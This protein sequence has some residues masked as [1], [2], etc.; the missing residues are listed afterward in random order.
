MWTQPPTIKLNRRNQMSDTPK[1][2][3]A[4]DGGLRTTDLVRLGSVAREKWP[5]QLPSETEYW[6][7]E[8]GEW[9]RGY[10]G[11]HPEMAVDDLAWPDDPAPEMGIRIP[12][13]NAI[14]HPTK[15]AK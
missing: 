11:W 4:A 14:E 2:N 7:R 1:L 12:L 15:G 13:P 9:I 10:G 3:E 6:D 8:Y 5:T